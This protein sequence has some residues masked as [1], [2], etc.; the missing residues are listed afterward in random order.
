MSGRV[1][2]VAGNQVMQR[3]ERNAW[4]RAYFSGDGEVWRGGRCAQGRPPRRGSLLV[5]D[6]DDLG[7]LRFSVPPRCLADA[8][9][10]ERGVARRAVALH[11]HLLPRRSAQAK[12]K[13]MSKCGRAIPNERGHARLLS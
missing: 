8:R 4:W 1:V 5:N 13:T 7:Q 6:D 12:E 3:R 2:V 11:E 9:V 10:R